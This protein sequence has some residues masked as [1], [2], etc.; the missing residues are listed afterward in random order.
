MKTFDELFDGVIKHEGYYA[1][2]TGDKGG[3]TYMGVA[4]NLHPKWEGWKIVD[5]HKEAFGVIKRNTKIDNSELTQMV[6]DFYKLIF[7]DNY[8][9]ERINNGSLQE[10]IFDWCV[11]SGH[12]GSKGVQRTLNQFFKTNLKLDG[13]VGNKTLVAINSCEPRVLFDAIKMARIRYYHAIATKGQ[14]YKFFKGWLNRI[15]NFNND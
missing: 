9:I 14:N 5:T 6:K 4:R 12:W 10:I 15:N 7:Y 3:E 1:N 8:N 13:I 2:V 11:N